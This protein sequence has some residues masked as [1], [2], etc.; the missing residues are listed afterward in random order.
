MSLRTV[1]PSPCRHSLSVPSGPALC[2]LTVAT[3]A[4]PSPAPQTER[5]QGDERLGEEGSLGDGRS[6]PKGV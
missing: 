2:W 5:A 4:A 1:V 6:P 3:Q